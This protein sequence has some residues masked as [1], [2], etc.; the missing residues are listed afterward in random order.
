[1]VLLR[2]G[3]IAFGPA[4]QLEFS[5]CLARRSTFCVRVPSCARATTFRRRFV[6]S[7]L[8]TEPG[9]VVGVGER[10][11]ASGGDEVG[12]KFDGPA[13]ATRLRTSLLASLAGLALSRQYR[14]TMSLP[15]RSDA[16]VCSG[17]ADQEKTYG[18]LHGEGP[19]ARED[20][21]HDR[22]SYGLADSTYFAADLSQTNS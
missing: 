3:S 6:L 15:S 10:L 12:G 9:A 13:D 2:V 7:L 21:A 14:P 5:T 17:A 4:V 1:V 19:W 11:P 20:R 16:L 22:E 8:A 18:H